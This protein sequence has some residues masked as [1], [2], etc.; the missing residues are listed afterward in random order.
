MGLVQHIQASHMSCQQSRQAPD[1]L[2]FA[3]ADRRVHRDDMKSS[4]A[5]PVP[6]S[7]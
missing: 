7:H 1:V 2:P 3:E 4:T 6:S 5:F